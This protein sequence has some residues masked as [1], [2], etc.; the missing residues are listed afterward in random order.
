M[1]GNDLNHIGVPGYVQ[2]D[3]SKMAQAFVKKYSEEL[4]AEHSQDVMA[5]V[6]DVRI[7]PNTEL[8]PCPY[9]KVVPCTMNDG[10]F[11]CEEWAKAQN[12]KEEK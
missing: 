7:F 6:T 8:F 5:F 12:K 2:E 11:G 4:D 10:C 3:Q 1:S 9:D